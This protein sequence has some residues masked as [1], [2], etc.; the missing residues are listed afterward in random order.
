MPGGSTGVTQPPHGGNGFTQQQGG[1][2]FFAALLP[3][4]ASALGFLGQRD[5]NRTAERMNQQANTP[6]PWA[7][8]WG[9][10]LT[11]QIPNIGSGNL[12]PMIPQ[13]MPLQ[14]Q[15]NPMWQQAGNMGMNYA[16]N[17][18]ISQLMQQGFQGNSQLLGGMNNAVSSFA[19][20]NQ[21]LGQLGLAGLMNAGANHPLL[22]NS[23]ESG[24]A[25]IQNLMNM[26]NGGGGANSPQDTGS[27]YSGYISRAFD[28][29]NGPGGA[30]QPSPRGDIESL[31]TATT[32][33]MT[34]DFQRNGLLP[35]ELQAVMN[36]NM[37]G[38]RQGIAQ[39]V[40]QGD[41]Q[42]EV[43]RMGSDLRYRDANDEA[44]RQMQLQIAGMQTAAQG[45]GGID[46]GAQLAFQR[47][48]ANAQNQL[49][50]AQLLGGFLTQGQGQRMD[51]YSGGFNPILN[52]MGQGTQMG[53]NAVGQGVNMMPQTLGSGFSSIMN[54]M[55]NMGSMF[56]TYG[57]QGVDNNL[58]AYMQNAGIG[59]ADM[60]MMGNLMS[61]MGGYYQPQQM[62][63][64]TSPWQTALGTGM[65]LYGMMGGMGNSG[66]GNMSN[67]GPYASGYQWG[68]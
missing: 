44:N 26:L 48:Q 10:Y 9:N 59:A 68:G 67:Y 38:S 1:N 33:Q 3:F 46:Q 30:G 29:L 60:N 62:A 28:G 27:S 17:P 63:P 14:A 54:P 22:Q 15:M 37:G 64:Q 51:A 5:S 19:Q 39:G 13:G 49:Q 7:Q 50:A 52:M 16:Q 43:S 8:A 58:A 2:K 53:F 41:F 11:G 18:M 40:A 32:D 34:R 61:G 21:G 47:E 36:G 20:Q 57:Q 65:S 45:A 6:P 24:S 66:G 55:M 12:N 23:G 4:A 56:Q 42:R 25:V 35:I 31:I